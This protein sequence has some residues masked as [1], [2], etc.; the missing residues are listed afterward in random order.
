MPTTQRSADIAALAWILLDEYRPG[1][2][3]HN[4]FT[5][6]NEE[7]GDYDAGTFT[8]TVQALGNDVAGLVATLDAVQL[9]FSAATVAYL[10]DRDIGRTNFQDTYGD[11]DVLDL[12]Q[13]FAS[14][15][16]AFLEIVQLADGSFF[17]KAKA[18][19]RNPVSRTGIA[20]VASLSGI[21][22]HILCPPLVIPTAI[23]GGIGPVTSLAGAIFDHKRKQHE[24]AERRA[25]EAAQRA[26]V[27]AR[28]ARHAAADQLREAA[29]AR[30][31]AENKERQDQLVAQLAQLREI[32][33][34]SGF[35]PVDNKAI[36]E[37]DIVDVRIDLDDA[38]HSHS[39]A[40]GSSNPKDPADGRDGDTSANETPRSIAQVRQ[41]ALN[42]RRRVVVVKGDPRR[43]PPHS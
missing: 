21:A 1:T 19:F 35:R 32:I 15:E 30:E 34:A 27:V 37:A 9:A 2:T 6:K 20:T 10:F 13:E 42:A 31:R 11:N 33:A 43:Q 5:E 24:E 38:A 4:L 18:V 36:Y 40:T 41:E 26:E 12:L 17:T 14:A 28:A 22:L 3:L 23:L 25:K 16:F 39:G 8:I 29:A 7:P